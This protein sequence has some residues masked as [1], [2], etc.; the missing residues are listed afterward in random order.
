M[1]RPRYAMV[2]VILLLAPLAALHAADDA[3][4]AIPAEGGCRQH[5]A[6]KR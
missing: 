6:V 3:A 4:T 5:S 2:L 1:N